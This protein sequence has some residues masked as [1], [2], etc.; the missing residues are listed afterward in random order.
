MK[1]SFR[2]TL[3]DEVLAF[4]S[5]KGV[6]FKNSL[7]LPQRK[8]PLLPPIKVKLLEMQSTNS[9]FTKEKILDMSLA[10]FRF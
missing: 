3:T 7:E 10:Y 4:R 1:W 6:I 9:V 8:T 2:P 5:W